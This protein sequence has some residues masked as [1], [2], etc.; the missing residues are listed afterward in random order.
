MDDNT[1]EEKEK[2]SYLIFSCQCEI[3]CQCLL[4]VKKETCKVSP[5]PRKCLAYSIDV[6]KRQIGVIPL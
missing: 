6:K 2:S 4:F 3:W 5:L 1:A